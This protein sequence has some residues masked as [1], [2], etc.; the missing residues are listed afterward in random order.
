MSE[1]VSEHIEVGPLWYLRRHLRDIEIRCQCPGVFLCGTP[2]FR[3]N[4]SLSNV[5]IHLNDGHGWSRERIADWLD[6][7]DADLIFR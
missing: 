4:D 6:T 3:I 7:L 5:I 1:Q 2:E